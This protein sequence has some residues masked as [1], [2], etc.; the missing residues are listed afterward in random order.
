MKKIVIP[1]LIVL[2]NSCSTDNSEYNGAEGN[3]QIE[4]QTG[5]FFSSNSQSGNTE[6]LSDKRVTL[7]DRGLNVPVG[8]ILVPQGFQLQYDLF[9]NPQTGVYDRYF[10]EL[11]SN[12]GEVLRGIANTSYYTTQGHNF[13][14]V[15]EYFIQN[16]LS[17]INNVQVG[18]FQMDAKRMNRE[19]YRKIIAQSRANGMELQIWEMPFIG[20]RNGVN[21]KGR[22]EVIHR[23]YNGFNGQSV[24]GHVNVRLMLSPTNLYDNLLTEIER[25]DAAYQPNQQHDQLLSQIIDRRTEQMTAQHNQRMASQQQAFDAH[26]QKMKGIYA[27][28]D[29]ANAQWMSQFRQGWS[30]NGSS[31]GSNGYT[32]H[33]SFIDGIR[34]TTTFND[35]YSGYNVQQDGNYDYWYTNGTGDYHGTDDPSFNQYSLGNDWQAIEPLQPE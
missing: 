34:E 28:N 15:C 31:S 7:L 23:V 33:E 32:Q 17:D 35:P 29:A 27:A 16:G 26:Q 21:V 12:K 14:N 4:M 19:D 9:T 13:Q 30:T 6:S 10:V 1:M 2:L 25:F 24:G 20:A 18:N 22:V 5:G 11:F 3:G 8:S